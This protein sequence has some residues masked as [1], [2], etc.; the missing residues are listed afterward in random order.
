[1]NKDLHDL[2]LSLIIL[3]EE[4]INY[5]IKNKKI[6]LSKK[7]MN[8]IAKIGKK[9]KEG[10]NSNNKFCE[11]VKYFEYVI[12]NRFSNEELHNFDDNLSDFKI[13]GTCFQL[14][15]IIKSEE[16]YAGR[17][18]SSQN[19]MLINIKDKDTCFSIYH[20]L[21]HMASTNRMITSHGQSGFSVYKDGIETCR[22]LNEGYTDLLSKRYF[23]NAGFKIGY[24]LEYQYAYLLELIVGK[25]KMEYMY[26]KSYPDKLVKELERYDS[27]DNILFFIKLLDNINNKNDNLVIRNTKINDITKMLIDWYIKKLILDG[28]DLLDKETKNKIDLFVQQIPNKIVK[29]NND[30]IININVNE[31]ANKILE[32]NIRHNAIYNRR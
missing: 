4:F 28:E 25:E 8:K 1:M 22:G 31:I 26:M 2:S 18:F 11:F 3:Y 30:G 14:A 9:T 29:L 12:R 27:I 5:L 20:E 7:P 16:K 19:T 6:N 32:E 24:P 23:G 17:Y 15:D 10:N 13:F 21:F